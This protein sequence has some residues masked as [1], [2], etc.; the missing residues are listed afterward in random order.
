MTRQHFDTPFGVVE[1]DRERID[2]IAEA[3]D[4]NPFEDEIVHRD[5]HSVELPLVMLA[6]VYGSDFKIVPVLCG[7][8]DAAA[9]QPEIERFLEA[10]RAEAEGEDILVVAGADLAHVGR[11]FGDEFEIDDNIIDHVRQRDETDL[12]HALAGD[13]A[14]WYASVMEDSNE[15]RVCGLQCVYSALRAVEGTLAN[16]ELLDYGYGHD[17]NGGIVSFAAVAAE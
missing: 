10:C 1:A 8:F 12:A 6:S 5:E 13:P 16:A 15:R 17:P 11:A 4:W 9:Q 7:P 3:C 14:A 2:R